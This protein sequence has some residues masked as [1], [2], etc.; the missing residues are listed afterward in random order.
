MCRS[1]ATAAATP[2]ECRVR[3]SGIFGAVFLQIVA[4]PQLFYDN[5]LTEQFE[6]AEEGRFY[7]IV[8][9]LQTDL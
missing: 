7:K 4:Q 5:N 8:F 6:D 9:R 1:I 3:Q 2:A